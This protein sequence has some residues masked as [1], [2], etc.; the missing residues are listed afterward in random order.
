MSL[1][2]AGAGA[3]PVPPVAKVIPKEL[4]L[5]GDT[6]VDNYFW[7]RERENPDVM[8]YVTAENAYTEAVFQ[9]INP[10]ADKVYKEMLV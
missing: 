8:A 5:F 2:L 10:L 3:E 6:R 9:P 7:M 1:V 4:K